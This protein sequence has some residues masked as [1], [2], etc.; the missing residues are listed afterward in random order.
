[1]GKYRADDSLITETGALVVVV[2]LLAL[3]VCVVVGVVEAVP[4]Q[5]ARKENKETTIV[6]ASKVMTSF[7]TFPS[8]K[9]DYLDQSWWSWPLTC[10]PSNL[11]NG[12]DFHKY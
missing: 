1:V 6:I 9:F 3:V 8:L 11:E 4:E 5:P 10:S 2:V 7:F 12:I